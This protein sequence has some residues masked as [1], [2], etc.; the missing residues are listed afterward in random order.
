MPMMLDDKTLTELCELRQKWIDL[1]C[2]IE[3]IRGKDDPS[4][5][6]LRLCIN[7]LGQ[8]MERRGMLKVAF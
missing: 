5:K 2:G 1:A 3:A 4:A 7:G 8:A 6:A